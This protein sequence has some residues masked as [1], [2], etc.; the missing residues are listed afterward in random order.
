MGK[1]AGRKSDELV[2]ACLHG[3]V[4][5]YCGGYRLP[6][7]QPPAGADREAALAEIRGQ[8][9]RADLLAEVAG[10]ML[11]FDGNQAAHD[12]LIEAGADT[13]LIPAWVEEGRRRRNKPLHSAP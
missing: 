6:S 8:T 4:S 13:G 1:R 2:T 5:R 7:L 11:G 3:I 9:T 12:L 10:L